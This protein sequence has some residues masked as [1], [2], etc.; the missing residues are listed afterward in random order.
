[1]E[2]GKPPAGHAVQANSDFAAGL[3]RQLAKESPGKNL[4][5]S[6]YSMSSALAMTAEGARGETAAQMGKVLGFPA[7]ARHVGDDAQLLPWNT[8]L[9]HTGMSALNER[10]NTKPTPPDV[11]AEITSLRA[12]LKASKAEELRLLSA[13]KRDEYVA[14]IAKT[15]L[16]VKKLN[17]LLA[18]VDQYELRVANAIYGEKTFPFERAYLDTVHKFYGTGAVTPVDF[19]NDHKAARDQ[20]NTWVEQETKGRIKELLSPDSLDNLT[21]LVLCNAVY[22]KGEWTTPFDAGQTK[23]ADFLTGAGQKVSVSMMQNNGLHG[24]RYAG[25]NADGK[26]FST[27]E[28]VALRGDVDPRTLYPDA[29][30]FLAVELPYK[31]DELSMVVLAPQDADGLASLEAKLTSANLHDWIGQLKARPVHVHLPKFKLET[32]YPALRETL[33]ELG[34]VRAFV[35]PRDPAKG[36]QFGGMCASADPMQQL[37]ITKV[38]HKAFVEVSEKGTEA[39][40]ASSVIMGAP[41]ALPPGDRPFTPTF[42]ADR[43]FIVCIRDTK[44]GTILFLG[45]VVKPTT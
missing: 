29:K 35:D 22:F 14:Q 15:G 41:T 7:A 23:P 20:I 10:F 26:F 1:V 30:G 4:F 12:E 3:Y 13:S 19:I 11:L 9:I 36:A 21:R 43:P 37:Y 17:A 6:P 38:C 16:V 44:T 5:F 28:R 40:A 31:G 34:M 8:A 27:P 25:F 24:A 45:R 42:R 18:R 33:K 32:E 39:A 2:P